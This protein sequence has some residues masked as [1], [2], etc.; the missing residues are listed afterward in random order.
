MTLPSLHIRRWLRRLLALVMAVLTSSLV[1]FFSLKP[2]LNSYAR[3][4]GM[5]TID[6]GTI[7]LA[8][9]V[10]SWMLSARE[11]RNS[12]G[13]RLMTYVW[14]ILYYG[15]GTIFML[16]LAMAMTNYLNEWLASV[17][18][19]SALE[20]VTSGLRL[21]LEIV[22]P[23]L[24]ILA[25]I[26]L[27]RLIARM[28]LAGRATATASSD[29]LWFAAVMWA[30]GAIGCWLATANWQP[31]AVRVATGEA[32]AVVAF[33]GTRMLISRPA[34]SSRPPIVIVILE[35]DTTR[36]LRHFVSRLAA[37]WRIGPVTLVAPQE[38]SLRFCGTHARTAARADMLSTLFPR[39]PSSLS[40]LRAEASKRENWSS[41]PVRECY[42]A[43]LL[44]SE[45]VGALLS[46]TCW[47]LIVAES[48]DLIAT[49]SAAER[50]KAIRLHLPVGRTFLLTGERFPPFLRN[51]PVTLA[52]AMTRASPV[53]MAEHL[54]KI[55]IERR[56]SMPPPKRVYEV[57]PQFALLAGVGLSVAVLFAGMARWLPAAQGRLGSTLILAFLVAINLCVA[58][59]LAVLPKRYWAFARRDPLRGRPKLAYLI[60]GAMTFTVLLAFSAL[61]YGLR[62]RFMTMP[63]PPFHIQARWLLISIVLAISLAYICD[64]YVLENEEPRWVTWVESAVLAI[65]M[66]LT[67]GIVV[68]W[69]R[70]DLPLSTP[71]LPT[72]T[73]LPVVFSAV[74]GVLIGSTVPSSYRRRIR[75]RSA[76]GKES[77]GEKFSD[78]KSGAAE[79]A[80]PPA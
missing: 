17:L 55:M 9:W 4:L 61:T 65:V 62:V 20:S 75:G 35:S 16:R 24:L 15:S 29:S 30:N 48:T 63:M 77:S 51:L 80:T 12:Y 53:H 73:W 5:V 47:V 57:E 41:L 21:S 78:V 67:G 60:S 1:A 40:T 71:L 6:R 19:G 54:Q 38:E 28:Q 46:A 36:S 32:L 25:L 8:V 45:T 42:P 11:A 64:D 72:S 26:A 13:F 7:V 58:A 14:A 22:L 10:L 34:L 37:C 18:R 56:P 68:E 70:A 74:I 79:A 59:E 49:A 43:P 52:G 50:L 23:V 27:P 66:A 69:I 3:W 33:V 39:S 76:G 31:D 2:G 44:W